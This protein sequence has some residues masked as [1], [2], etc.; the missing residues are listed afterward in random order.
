MSKSAISVLVYGIYLAISGLMLLFVPNLLIGS[1]GIEPTSEVWIRLSGILLMA[2][3]VYYFLGSKY[4]IVVIFKAT[5][6]IRF[7]IIFFF[8]AFALLSMVSPNIIVLS[9]ID[10]FGGIWTY[11]MLKK[12]GNFERSRLKQ[13]LT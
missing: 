9:L 11:V 5:V 13:S 4:E 12:E 3:S 8:T 10:L 6:F 2:V 1:L 7:S